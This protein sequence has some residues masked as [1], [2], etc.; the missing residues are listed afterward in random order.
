MKL[1]CSMVFVC[2]NK[3]FSTSSSNSDFSSF[4]NSTKEARLLRNDI[5]SLKS[6]DVTI[7][8]INRPDSQ[9]YTYCLKNGFMV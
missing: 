2:F 7:K 9:T 5:L 6:E 8:I 4:Q 3:Y 1:V